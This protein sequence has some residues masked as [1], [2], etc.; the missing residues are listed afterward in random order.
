LGSKRKKKDLG[1][2]KDLSLM[3]E[4]G[5]GAMRVRANGGFQKGTAENVRQWQQKKWSR[6][7]FKKKETRKKRER[8]TGP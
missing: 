8:R 1:E 6:K 5:G 2:K 7:D 3:G 4:S